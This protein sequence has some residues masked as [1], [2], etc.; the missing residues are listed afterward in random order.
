M[1]HLQKDDKGKRSSSLIKRP[2]V[3]HRAAKQSHTNTNLCRGL[4][5]GITSLPEGTRPTTPLC[6]ERMWINS[7]GCVVPSQPG[8]IPSSNRRNTGWRKAATPTPVCP[9]GGWLITRLTSSF[10]LPSHILL[11]WLISLSCM[12]FFSTFAYTV[13]LKFQKV[14]LLRP[15]M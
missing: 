9:K 1:S 14:Y 10:Q 6:C 12:S 5:T 13:C 2:C 4:L 11:K 15:K 3:I 8:F 7:F